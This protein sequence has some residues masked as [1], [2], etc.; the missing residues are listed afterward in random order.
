MRRGIVGGHG[1][2]QTTAKVSIYAIVAVPSAQV[3]PLPHHTA[4]CHSPFLRQIFFAHSVATVSSL[5]EPTV[6]SATDSGISGACSGCIRTRS[7]EIRQT[8]TSSLC[9]REV[10]KFFAQVLCVSS[11][12]FICRFGLPYSPCFEQ[13]L[14]RQ[15]C[16]CVESSC[17]SSLSREHN[18]NF[19][20]CVVP[21]GH[22][23]TRAGACMP[24]LW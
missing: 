10:R 9:G 15:N 19:T 18:W 5:A 12:T 17:A 13:V 23:A 6:R 14:V 4:K 3:H 16:E 11:K 2:V 1:G 7:A 21:N 8:P 24:L 22:S 20:S